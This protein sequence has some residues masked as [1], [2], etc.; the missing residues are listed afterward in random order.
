MALPLYLAFKSRTRAMLYSCMLGGLSQPLG[1][2]FAAAWFKIAGR[3]GS[4]PGELG[5]GVLFGITAGIMTGVSLHLIAEGLTLDH[6][7]GLSIMG[8]FVG[9]FVMGV[10]NALTR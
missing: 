3:D 4:E 1:A 5:Y 7:K 6:R 8:G 10:A 2:G 9:I